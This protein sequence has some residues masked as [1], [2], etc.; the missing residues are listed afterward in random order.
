MNIATDAITA[1]HMSVG[2]VS[3]DIITTGYL[4]A[5][6]IRGGAIRGVDIDAL[7]IRAGGA[8]SGHTVNARDTLLLQGVNVGSTI[9]NL[10]A[11]VTALE[12]RP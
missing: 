10:M 1:R 2:S 12:Q 4:S 8:L 3:A 9:N 5:D 7:D 11:R 6:R